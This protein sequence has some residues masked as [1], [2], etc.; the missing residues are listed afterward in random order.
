MFDRTQEQV[1]QNTRH[2]S[3]YN[4]PA[5]TRLPVHGYS[6][7]TE[8]RHWTALGVHAVI[9]AARTIHTEIAAIR[10]V[11][12]TRKAL[13][14]CVSQSVML[15]KSRA[16]SSR[17]NNGVNIEN[18]ALHSDVFSDDSLYICALET[19][20]GK[21][22]RISASE[23]RIEQTTE[24]NEQNWLSSADRQNDRVSE[25]ETEMDYPFDPASRIGICFAVARVQAIAILKIQRGSRQPRN[26]SSKYQVTWIKMSLS[27]R[28]LTLPTRSRGPVFTANETNVQHVTM[29]VLLNLNEERELHLQRYVETDARSQRATNIFDK[30]AF[31]ILPSRS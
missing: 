19:S 8:V 22:G 4:I 24:P 26:G 6:Q 20:S 29:K 1:D 12:A 3:T 16:T 30:H 15:T 27:V 13:L 17:A 25:P 5:K 18:V 2:N 21:N 9:Q 10:C 11:R 14:R 7:K 28:L 23:R 31:I